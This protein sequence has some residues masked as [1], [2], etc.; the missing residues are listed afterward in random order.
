VVSQ[1]GVRG[2]TKDIHHA[3][4]TREGKGEASQH[5]MFSIRQAPRGCREELSAGF[6]PYRFLFKGRGGRMGE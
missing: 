3:G 5:R 6:G 1:S 4:S 2:E